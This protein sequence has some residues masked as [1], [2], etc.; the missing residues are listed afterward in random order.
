M[1]YLEPSLPD[2]PYPIGYASGY[3]D[4]F[5]IGHLRYLQLAAQHCDKLI[6]GIPSDQ[7]VRADHRTSPIIPC[8]QRIE[9]VAA[10]R[11]V[12]E[13]ICV[14]S[15]MD[16][17][18]AYLEFLRGLGNQAVFIGGDWQGSARW[19]RLG[20][21]L[22]AQGLKIHFLPRT[23]AISSSLIKQRLAVV[24]SGTGKG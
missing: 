16:Q 20:P 13:V 15:S 12:N 6:V 7:V 9:I 3:F 14:D 5:H 21:V 19:N 1:T 10:L 22:H 24:N 18:D 8:E 23:E 11:C 2:K 17:P 4:L